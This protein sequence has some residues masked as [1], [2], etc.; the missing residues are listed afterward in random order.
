MLILSNKDHTNLDAFSLLEHTL[1]AYE[2]RE[3]FYF[4]LDYLA[5]QTKFGT[6]IAFSFDCLK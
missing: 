4:Q 1:T 2:I 6:R 5:L 3:Y